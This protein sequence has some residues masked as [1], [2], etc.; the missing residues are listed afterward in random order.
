MKLGNDRHSWVMIDIASL[1]LKMRA[2]AVMHFDVTPI[3]IVML[4]CKAIGRST[5]S[6][7]AVLLCGVI[8]VEL[9]GVGGPTNTVT[10]LVDPS[11]CRCCTH[12]GHCCCPLLS[13]VGKVLLRYRACTTSPPQHPNHGTAV[14]LPGVASS[15]KEPT[16]EKS[17]SV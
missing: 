13:L 10:A 2:P 5:C 14:D 9:G 7:Q 17:G 16:I 4:C 15:T 1:G 8:I 11:G 6:N 3:C 12:C